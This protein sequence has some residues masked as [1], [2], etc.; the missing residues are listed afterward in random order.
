MSVSTV[1]GLC[2]V[3]QCRE[4]GIDPLVTGYSLPRE[5]ALEHRVAFGE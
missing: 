4:V 2:R 5:T 1:R 3:F